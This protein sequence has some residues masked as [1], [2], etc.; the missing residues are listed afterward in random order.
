[1]SEVVAAKIG[2]RIADKPLSPEVNRT[3]PMRL[4]SDRCG[5]HPKL[6]C[7]QTSSTAAMPYFDWCVHPCEQRIQD[8]GAL[9]PCPRQ[10]NRVQFG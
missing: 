7:Y 1:M 2:A 3:E 5:Q 6:M 4:F 10:D 9:L 8:G